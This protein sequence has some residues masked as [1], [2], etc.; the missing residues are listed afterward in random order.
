MGSGLVVT[1]P[2]MLLKFGW[3]FTYLVLKHLVSGI[4]VKLLLFT[5]GKPPCDSAS[6]GYLGFQLIVEGAKKDVKKGLVENRKS[7]KKNLWTYELKKHR[8][9]PVKTG[10]AFPCSL[11]ILLLCY[12]IL[13][14]T[15]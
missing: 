11:R 2:G 6:H 7:V 3:V 9:Q 15:F 4:S 10:L 14:Q 8:L 1:S 5:C 12:D 13:N